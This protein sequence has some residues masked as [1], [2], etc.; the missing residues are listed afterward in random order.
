MRFIIT[1][2]CTSTAIFTLSAQNFSETERNQL[3]ISTPGLFDGK[4]QIIIDTNSLEGEFCFPLPGAKV[5]SHYGRGGGRHSGIDIK[6]KANDT[7]YSVFDG[8]VR[9]A[10]TYS[11][12][13]KVVV[14]RHPCGLETVYSHNS[15][16]LVKSGDIVRAGQAIAL[17][18]RTG[19]AS[20][21][22][23]HFETRIN[24]QAF[25]PTWLIDFEQ[26]KLKPNNIKCTKK[27]GG[28]LITTEPKK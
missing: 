18:G 26:Y 22:H 8:V 28:V 10:K 4:K 24:G 12:Y 14:I 1:L 23:L 19:R 2:L 21:E 3:K 16:D 9:M 6:T 25:N 17:T 11:G 7:I 15:K 13:G 20:T 5:I 27:K